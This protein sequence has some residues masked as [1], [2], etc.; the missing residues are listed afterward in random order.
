MYQDAYEILGVSRSASADEI[1]RAFHKLAHKYHPDKAGGD[2]EQFKKISAA[3]AQ[4]KDRPAAGGS[5]HYEGSSD[6]V[7]DMWADRMRRQE[8][9]FTRKYST[10]FDEASNI[11]SDFYAEI[12]RK[13]RDN[14]RRQNEQQQ[15]W[16][17]AAA[18]KEAENAA[19]RAQQG[20][21]EGPRPGE[22]WQDYV[23]RVYD[24]DKASDAHA[25]KHADDPANV[26]KTSYEDM[27]RRKQDEIERQQAQWKWH[28]KFGR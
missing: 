17:Y 19:H 28:K 26:P 20:A 13:M 23:N 27:L 18:Q 15:F 8:G 24:W 2:A 1:K 21:P 25:Q 6:P 10:F 12:L 7:S 4:V 11:D 14:L 3:Y 22:T 16:A 5:S 9:G